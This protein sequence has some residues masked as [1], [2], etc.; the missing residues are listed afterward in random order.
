VHSLRDW[1][2]GEERATMRGRATLL[3]KDLAALYSVR[4]ENRQLPSFLQ[5]VRI[6]ALTS[7]R[8]WTEPQ[9]RMMQNAGRYH[10]KKGLLLTV[11]L[12]LV[13]TLGGFL[14]YLE[15][16][17]ANHAA[18][19]VR[20]L[21]TADIAQ[22]PGLVEELEPYRYLTNARLEEENKKAEPESREK[23]NTSIALL[24]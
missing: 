21:K 22:V 2:N 10:A 11:L 14:A 16:S 4:S 19:L 8:A 6:R 1:L 20:L 13:A 24:P 5:W 15:T 23:L 7:K 9:R 12:L 18:V 17:W 3:L